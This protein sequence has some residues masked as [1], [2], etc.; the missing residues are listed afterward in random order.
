MGFTI[1]GLDPITAITNTVK[2]VLD[3]VLPD[4]VANDQAK[5]EITRLQVSGEIQGIVGQLQVDQAEAS[6]QNL[7]VAGWRPFVGWVCGIGFAWKFVA[8]PFVVTCLVAFHS[9]F[10]A[11]QLPQMDLSELAPL[12]LGMLGLGVLRTVDKVQGTSNGH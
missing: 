4:K 5:A 2:D 8:Q 11:S 7:F 6:N 10:E 12:L 1:G 9:H 3:R